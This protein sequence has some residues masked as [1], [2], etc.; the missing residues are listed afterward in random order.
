MLS[1]HGLGC[2]DAECA[3]RASVPIGAPRPR[4]CHVRTSREWPYC[5]STSSNP[6]GLRFHAARHRRPGASP[7]HRPLAENARRRVHSTKALLARGQSKSRASQV[8][9]R[10]HSSCTSEVRRASTG[11]LQGATPCGNLG[12]TRSGSA[13]PAS[14]SRG[15]SRHEGQK[16]PRGCRRRLLLD[17]VC[18]RGCSRVSERKQPVVKRCLH[19]QCI[20]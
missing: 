16:R 13:E 20:S 10:M 3:L 15:I 11:R 2:P 6:I 18:L 12:C 14:N 4:D 7:V 5:W 1:A 9:A 19:A 8:L 17:R